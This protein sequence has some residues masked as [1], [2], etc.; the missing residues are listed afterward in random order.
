MGNEIVMIHKEIR[1]P[2]VNLGFALL[3]KKLN[4]YDKALTYVEKGIDFFEKKLQCVPYNYPG[5]ESEPIE[6]T[7][8]VFL[9]KMF[10]N[11]RLEFKCP[12]NLKLYVNI[13]I[14]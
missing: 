5:L 3:F 7:R 6:E 10:I 13:K 11:L 12:P 2:A 8:P 9:E 1:F 4:R 14:V